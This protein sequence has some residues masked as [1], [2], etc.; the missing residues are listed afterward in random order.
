[1]KRLYIPMVILF[2][3]L[4]ASCSDGSPEDKSDQK[5]P[6]ER[7]N[8][9]TQNDQTFEIIPLYKEIQEYTGLAKD[10]PSMNTKKKYKEKVVEP[11]QKMASEKKIDIGSYYSTYFEPTT[12]I[13]Q[14]E[15]NTTQLL[16]NQ[17]KINKYIKESLLSSAKLLPGNNKTIFIM[18]FNP[19]YTDS[20]Q[21]MEGVVAFNLSK[22]AILVQLVPSFKEIALKYTIAREYNHTIAREYGDDNSS[23][24]LSPIIYEGKADSFAAKVY[25]EHNVPWIKPLAAEKEKI[26]IDEIRENNDSFDMHIYNG[27]FDG[28]PSK[29]IPRWSNYKIGYKI[30]QSFIKNNPDVSI[31]EWTKLDYNEILKGSDYSHLLE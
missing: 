21:E 14:L 2:V 7:S 30:T 15:E 29:G 26:V 31:D 19:E 27:L 1:M 6:S 9:F 5:A 11:F 18:P 28:D 24:L 25:P 20:I 23:S 3:L 17:D 8:T 10:N 16:N 22:D 12:D 4:L 13:Q